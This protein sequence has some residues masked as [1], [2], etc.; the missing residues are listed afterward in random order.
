MPFNEILGAGR[1]P[2]SIPVL[3]KYTIDSTSGSGTGWTNATLVTDSFNIP[4]DGVQIFAMQITL[5]PRDSNST[6]GSA[7][8]P[9]IAV[10]IDGNLIALYSLQNTC[11]DSQEWFVTEMVPYQYYIHAGSIMSVEKNNTS[12]GGNGY[13]CNYSISLFGV[14]V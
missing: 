7:V 3:R 4:D 1:E 13:Q 6:T 12:V 11:A 2:R 9:N 5:R 14:L 10:K 8:A